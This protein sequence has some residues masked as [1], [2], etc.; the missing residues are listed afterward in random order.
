MWLEITMTML[1]VIQFFRLCIE[2]SRYAKEYLVEDMTEDAKR[3]F[4]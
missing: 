2:A 4:T 3:M 1:T